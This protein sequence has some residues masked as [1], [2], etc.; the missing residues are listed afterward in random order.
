MTSN[1]DASEV[2]IHTVSAY[3]LT[4][5]QFIIAAAIVVVLCV[6]AYAWLRKTDLTPGQ[7]WPLLALRTAFAIVLLICLFAPVRDKMQTTT[8]VRT[9]EVLVAVDQSASLSLLSA[10]KPRAATLEA[11]KA[12]LAKHPEVEHRLYAIGSDLR[13]LAPS[14]APEDDV[15]DIPADQSTRLVDQLRAMAERVDPAKGASLLLITDGQDTDQ[16]PIADAVLALKSHRV[17]TFPLTLPGIDRPTLLAR[18]E[19]LNAPETV[20]PR[21]LFPVHA[22]M[23]LRGMGGRQLELTLE[24]VSPSGIARKLDTQTVSVKVDGTTR[25]T[26]E[27][28]LDEPGPAR[29]RATLRDPA[30]S[31]V[32]GSTYTAVNATIQ[33][34]IRVL[35]VQGALSWEY[36]F[37]RQA[38]N[39]NPSIRLDSVA[40]ISRD[41]LLTQKDGDPVRYLQA[42]NPIVQTAYSNTPTTGRLTDQIAESWRHYD[43][44]ILADLN[45]DEL[46]LEE[47]IGLLKLVRER[48]GGVLFFS[49]NHRRAARLSGTLLE[50]ILPVVIDPRYDPVYAVDHEAERFIAAMGSTRRAVD[51]N[52]ETGFGRYRTMRQASEGGALAHLQTMNLTHEGL[53]SPIWRNADQKSSLDPPPPT[54][55]QHTQVRLV[56]PGATVLATGKSDQNTAIPVLVVQD[57]GAGSSGFLGIDALWRWRMSTDSHERGYD[58]F[59]QQFVQHLARRSQRSTL[60]L[61]R[62]NARPGDTLTVTGDITRGQVQLFYQ[63]LEPDDTMPPT[64]LDTTVDADGATVTARLIVPEV[65]HLRVFA[66]DTG[67]RLLAEV[68]LPI[69]RTDLE[70][71]FAGVNQTVLNQLATETGGEMIDVDDIDSLD[72]L[73]E[74]TEVSTTQVQ[75]AEL[76]RNPWVFVALLVFY[77]GELLLRH[78][79]TLV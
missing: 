29:L 46:S 26:F 51:L 67:G 78:F 49:G 73:L 22:I 6:W 36:R 69:R 20:R 33:P 59:W 64:A 16:A 70:T 76:W 61:D 75:R 44:V 66:A 18:I 68:I 52:Q 57:I 60:R 30:N 63:P 74:R 12:F 32:F 3:G 50:E 19:S 55:D 43:V 27:H 5:W 79:R 14:P 31:H 39:E 48:G 1:V 17:M 65:D 56:K 7:R 15:A 71:E 9:P 47:Q 54:Y 37:L 77:C 23:R 62:Y 38:F 21:Q 42:K 8:S 4:V 41:R 11:I 53:N 10:D 28:R 25:A 45:P 35:Y 58:R 34:T 2:S 72:T 40:R 13:P 24:D